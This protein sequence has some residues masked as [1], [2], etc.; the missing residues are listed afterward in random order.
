MFGVLR[1]VCCR[2]GGNLYVENAYDPVTGWLVTQ[3]YGNGTIVSNAYDILGRTVGIYHGRARSPSAP[4]EILAFF[5]YAYDAEGRRISQTTAEGVE[6]YT[7][8]TVGQLT[9]VIYPDGSEEHFTYDAVG[10]RISRTGCQPVQE[11]TY[12]ANNLNQYT[13]IVNAQA[14]RSTME[15]DLDGNMTRKGDTRYFY[16]IQNRLIAV[17]N[18]TTDIAWACEYDVFGNRT[19]VIDHGTAKET[20]FVQGSLASAVAEFDGEGAVAMRHILLGSVRI[21]DWE[22][23]H[24]GGG[25]ENTIRYYHADGLASTR[26]LTDANGDTIGTASYRAFGEVRTGRD[27]LV[28]SGISA[29]WVGTLGVER[30][31][32]T[33]LVFMRNRYYDTE[34]GR[35]IQMDPIGYNSGEVNQYLYCAN[36]GINSVDSTG[37]LF[38]TTHCKRIRYGDYVEDKCEKTIWGHISEWWDNLTG[39]S[40]RNTR[41]HYEN[42]EK[43]RQAQ[44]QRATQEHAS[45]NAHVCYSNYMTEWNNYANTHTLS[46]GDKLTGK[47]LYKKYQDY[48]GSDISWEQAK[49]G[50]QREWDD[51]ESSR[52]RRW[53]EGCDYSTHWTFS[54]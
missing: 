10:N 35:F 37:L 50:Y 54:D 17:T 8:D 32:A 38:E 43:Q 41:K 14:A 18:T 53:I 33:G 15:Y 47:S 34:Q 31:D 26:L 2:C 22:S 20:L 16:D 1:R 7:Y 42:V 28:A 25:D 4:L 27:A 36:N 6:R 46:V 12:A 13:E 39:A 30:D 9:D 3:T 23:R 29:G 19:K 21:A 51:W 40:S 11:E 44:A 5:E 52:H 49:Q 45:K 24:L 48:V